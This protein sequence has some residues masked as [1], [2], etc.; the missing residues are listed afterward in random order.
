MDR[1]GNAIGYTPRNC[2]SCG[3]TGFRRPFSAR[4]VLRGGREFLMKDNE[5]KKRFRTVRR[6]AQVRAGARVVLR[7]DGPSS[8]C[9]EPSPR[10]STPG[11]DRRASENAVRGVS[12]L[13]QPTAL[14]DLRPGEAVLD[15]GPEGHRRAALLSGQ[16]P[17]ERP[18]GPRL[19]DEM[20]ALPGRISAS[21]AGERGVPQGRDRAHP[22]P[23]ASVDVVIS[24]CVINLTAD[25]DRALREAFRVLRPGGRFAVSDIVLQG[26]M[27]DQLRRDME[28][29]TGCVAGAL[30]QSEYRAKLTAAGFTDVTLQVTGPG[31]G[32][33]DEAVS[34]FV[35]AT[36]LLPD[37]V[38]VGR[39]P[40]EELAAGDRDRQASGVVQ[41]ILRQ[42]LDSGPAA[43]R[44][45]PSRWCSR[46]GLRPGAATR[47]AYRP[48]GSRWRSY[49]RLARGRIVGARSRRR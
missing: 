29:W 22:L 34:A 36:N 11:R 39:G 43:A 7:G 1:R 20:L 10:P 6:A 33:G 30:E 37:A 13:R 24:N 5:L 19:T 41:R 47:R 48:P 17:R 45:W 15:L 35:L 2:T 3:C 14:I 12:R 44:W 16:A 32:S 42:D 26:K 4:S 18:T 38:E 9:C 23:D 49:A 31:C 21:Q 46:S 40:D 8:A 25:K 27:S 28:S